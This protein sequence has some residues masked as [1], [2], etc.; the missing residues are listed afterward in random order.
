MPKKITQLPAA[1][2]S[3]VVNATLYEIV[4]PGGVSKKATGAQIAKA[5]RIVLNTLWGDIEKVIS[6]ADFADDDTVYVHT[7]LIGLVN[8]KLLCIGEAKVNRAD[9]TYTSSTGKITLLG[10]LTFKDGSTIYL[11]YKKA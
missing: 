4:T 2:D 3:E 9:Y 8:L 6:A 5:T 7:D 1:D 11:Q 10:G